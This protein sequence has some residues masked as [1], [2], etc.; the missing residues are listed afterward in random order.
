ME[1]VRDGKDKKVEGSSDRFVVELLEDGVEE[2]RGCAISGHGGAAAEGCHFCLINRSGRKKRQFNE[3]AQ[4]SL[5][6]LSDK[7]S[8]A[9]CS[10]STVLAQLHEFLIPVNRGD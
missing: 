10:I 5:A 2:A 3:C 7:Q 1:E 6:R 8:C 9:R 4:Y